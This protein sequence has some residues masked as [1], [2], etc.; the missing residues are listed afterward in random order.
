M[1]VYFDE[2]YLNDYANFSETSGWLYLVGS[3]FIIP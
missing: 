1:C 2:L 3:N